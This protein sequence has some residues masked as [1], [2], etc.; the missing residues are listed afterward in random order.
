MGAK[1][2][3]V[4]RILCPYCCRG[5]FLLL[6]RLCRCTAE[7]PGFFQ[8]M[9]TDESVFSYFRRPRSR[10][11]CACQGWRGGSSQSMGAAMEGA[12]R[13]ASTG[14]DCNALVPLPRNATG[15]RTPGG[16][17]CGC[18]CG[19]SPRCRPP[20]MRQV[21]ARPGAVGVGVD[22]GEVRS[23]VRPECDR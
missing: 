8:Q 6:D 7:G 21:I 13:P 1:T 3:C 9:P 14:T 19:R 4:A 20:G 16:G 11:T 2:G 17:G 18:G 10:P 12:P 23:V 22:G 15:N 5:A